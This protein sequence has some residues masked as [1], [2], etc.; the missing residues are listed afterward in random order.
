[1]DAARK[2]KLG[3]KWTC[4]SCQVRF[5]DLK[6]PEPICPKC[7]ADQRESPAFEKPKTKRT[8]KKV[9][10]KKTVAKRAKKV[11]TPEEEEE[12]AASVDE[13]DGADIDGPD[14][15]ISTDDD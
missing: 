11:P 8:R 4:Y 7:Q 15:E 10:K 6:K 5:Y 14:V 13:I 9:A 1:M 3:T 12:A 2:E